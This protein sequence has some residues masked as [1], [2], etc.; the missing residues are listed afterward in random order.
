M[1]MSLAE[2]MEGERREQEEAVQDVALLNCQYYLRSTGHYVL[3]RQC[4]SIGSRAQKHWFHVRK[5]GA[6]S[7]ILLCM[8]PRSAG[9]PLPFTDMTCKTLN[10]LLLLLQHPYIFSELS[11]DFIPD[12]NLCVVLQTCSKGG[13]L[14]DAIYRSKPSDCYQIKYGSRGTPVAVA[15][16]QR[17][18][19]QILVAMLFLAEKGLTSL[20]HLHSGNVIFQKDG[21]CRLDVLAN[22]F[23][24]VKPKIQPLIK[25]Q[26]KEQPQ[27]F[28]SLCFGHLLFEMCTGYELDCAAPQPRHLLDVAGHDAVEILNFIFHSEVTPSIK[29]IAEHAFFRCVD[30]RELRMYN[31][32]PI[33]MTPAMK[34]LL[35]AC[36]EASR[37]QSHGGRHGRKSNA[38]HATV[39]QRR[40]SSVASSS[41]SKKPVKRPPQPLTESVQTSAASTSKPVAARNGPEV[42]PDVIVQSSSRV[43]LMQD[44]RQ[45][46]RLK[47]V[48][49]EKLVSPRA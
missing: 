36:N 9:C 1:Q 43:A 21:Q 14:K 34:S 24:S 12:Q 38:A 18:C 30:L 39:E 41:S 40:R 33:K 25:R 6:K 26:I 15:A 2:R 35:K 11:I 5:V 42:V 23:L 22:V 46:T 45:G 29:E 3:L 10:E 49:D 20:N 13:S 32:A 16:M 17:Q 37:L 19:K 27:A 44:I 7:H 48:V 47:H 28:D 8:F 31:P 4:P